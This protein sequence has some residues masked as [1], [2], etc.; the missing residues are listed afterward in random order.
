MITQIVFQ[1]FFFTLS[2]VDT[3]WLDLHK[4]ISNYAP[5]FAKNRNIWRIDNII[6]YPHIVAIY[7]HQLFGIFHEE[8]IV[9]YLN[10]KDY[11]YR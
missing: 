9:K 2:V 8:I 10:S 11:W 4:N 6:N 7:M 1:T 3:K 5:L